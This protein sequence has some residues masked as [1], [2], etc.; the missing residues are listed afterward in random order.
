MKGMRNIDPDLATSI[1]YDS[2]LLNVLGIFVFPSNKWN[3]Q[4]ASISTR[5]NKQCLFT[6]W[7]RVSMAA[8]C[9][10]LCFRKQFKQRN[11]AHKCKPGR[12]ALFHAN[13]I[14][15][16]SV[17]GRESIQVDCFTLICCSWSVNF[18]IQ[19][20]DSSELNSWRLQ[21]FSFNL[22]EG[23]RARVS[24]N[25]LFGLYE[26]RRNESEKLFYDPDSLFRWL[27]I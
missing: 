11:H 22:F 19:K 12:F 16:D 27:C 20:T 9:M 17:V 2:C 21:H 4:V 18:S 26:L 13:Y 7:T 6:N 3:S 14:E 23:P 24:E 10:I 15:G 8:S 1:R 25:N 5:I